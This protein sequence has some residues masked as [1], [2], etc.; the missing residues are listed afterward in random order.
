MTDDI[1]IFG[2]IEGTMVGGIY[3]TH[4]ILVRAST[5]DEAKTLFESRMDTISNDIDHHDAPAESVPR[6]ASHD[7]VGW[8]YLGTVAE[9]M[10][11]GTLWNPHD[12]IREPWTG[13]EDTEVKE[14]V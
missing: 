10:D 3:D 8:N 6:N 13:D 11:E 12:E 1:H 9:N 14:D 2:T 4:T 5:S 7:R